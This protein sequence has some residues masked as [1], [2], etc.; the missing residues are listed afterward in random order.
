MRK[1]MT[2]IMIFLF[3]I[4]MIGCHRSTQAADYSDTGWAFNVG[5]NSSTYQQTETR[6]KYTNSAV[7]FYWQQSFNGVARLSVEPYAKISSTSS[8]V[9]HAGAM[10]PQRVQT[11]R[12]PQIGQYKI[13]NFVNEQGKQYVTV[14]V[15]STYGSGTVTGVWSP[16]CFGVYPRAEAE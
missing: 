14:G 11:Y 3:G 1:T 6:R 4:V 5:I 7:Y 15:R 8:T 10:D 12:I 13:T 9:I 16:D 2:Y